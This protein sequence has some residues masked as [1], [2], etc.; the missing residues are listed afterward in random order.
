MKTLRSQLI[1]SHILP[2]LI[3]IPMMG[4][5]LVYFLENR[6]ILPVLE[7]QLTDDAIVISK[8][9]RSQPQIFKDAD[10]A[11]SLL[12]DIDLETATRVMFLNP[13]GVLIASSDPA[14][15]DRLNQVLTV[16]GITQAQG[17]EISKELDFSRGL[18]GEVVDI[19]IPVI[20]IEKQL[21]GIVRVSF[22]YVTVA[23]QLME[24]R[25]LI[26]GV[27][28]LG[29]LLGVILGALLALNI[30]HPI[31]KVTQ[32]VIDLARGTRTESLTE[33]GPEEIQIL[34]KAVNFLVVRLRELRQN[35]Q[36]LL[37]NLVHELGRPL[38]GL[39]TGIQVL[40]RGAKNDP[41]VLDELLEGME[42]ETN[43]LRRLLEDLSHLHDEIVGTRELHFQTV[44]LSKWLK[45]I[46]HPFE[47]EAGESNL[48]WG[49]DIPEDLPELK[50][51]PERMAQV[52]GN[53]LANAIKYTQSGGKVNVSAG[54][55][56]EMAWIEVKDTGTGIPFDEQELIFEPFFR[57]TQRQRIKQGMGL[58]LH[59]AK[60]YVTAHD[61][62]IELKSA[63]GS[64]SCF[65]IW[66]PKLV[67]LP[68]ISLIS[69]N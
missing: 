21:I 8:I 32:A 34:Q 31:N 23:E 56:G 68:D 35:R 39:H 66:L 51:D 9:A 52:I 43:I 6:I 61:G 42:T 59:I 1:I 47:E 4:I 2:I 44:A 49:S 5:A 30:N 7:N 64:G 15:E 63:P 46:L 3:I 29:I 33:Q 41:Q 38:G 17:G 10:L 67:D 48:I 62:R 19:F 13:E 28:T 57:G 69:E 37:A 50:I 25:F 55:R 65:T 60:D 54:E 58:G 20:D 27:L 24:M 11:G 36:Q 40:Q 26:V 18:H 53:L 45:S 22:R 16:N 12:E 14:D